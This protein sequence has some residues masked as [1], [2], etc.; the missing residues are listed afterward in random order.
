MQFERSAG[1]FFSVDIS[2][3]VFVYVGV[4]ACMHACVFVSVDLFAH[5]HVCVW[6]GLHLCMQTNPQKTPILKHNFLINTLYL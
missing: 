3:T 5:M 1:G 6:M 4:F 2:Y